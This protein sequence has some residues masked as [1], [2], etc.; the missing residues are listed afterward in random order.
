M[1]EAVE[2]TTLEAAIGWLADTILANLPAGGKLESWIRQAGLGNDVEKLKC[3]VQAV[4]MTVSAVQGRASRNKPLAKSLAL[5]KEL[6]YDADDVVDELDCY[7]L[8]QELQPETLLE[9]DGHGTHQVERSS[10]NADV[11]SSGNSRLR[12]EGWNH[13]EITEFE[14]NGGPAKARC[15]HCQKQV[16]CT[17]KMGTSVLHNHL[18]SKGC[19]NKRRASGSSSSTANAA[20]IPMPIVTGSRKRMRTG[21]ESTHITAVNPNGWNKDAF[22][23]RIQDITS[24]LQGKHG[25]VTRLL[26]ILPSDSVAASSI[27]CQTTILDPCRRTSGLFQGKVYGRAQERGSIKTLIKE[28]KSTT[29]VTVLPIVGIGGVGKTVL[30]QLVYNDTALQSLFDHKIWIWV[31]KDFDEMR[32]TREMLDCV[33]QETCDGLCSFTKLQE[34]LKGHIKSKRVLLILDDVWEVMDDCRWNKLLAPFKSDD[35]ANGN[36]IILTTRK[37]SVAKKRGT[38]GPI[39]LNG[40]KNDDFWLFFKAC[41]FGDENYEAQASLSDIGQIIAQKLKGNPLAAQTVGVLLKDRLTVDHWSSILMTEDWKSLQHTG[42]IMS[43]LKLSYDEMPYLVQQC[44]SYCSIFPYGYE[45]HD[46]ELVRLW[47][48]QGFVK[49]DHSSKSLEVV[50][51][52]YLTDLVNLGLFEEVERKRSSL[53]S[54][55]QTCYAMC[56]LMHD[57]A[58]LVSRTECATLDGLQCS[59]VLPNVHHL[60]IVTD[61]VY[62]RDDQTENIPRNE[63]FEFFL[64]NIVASVRKLR[65]LVL[66]GE[67]D[68]FFFKAFQNVFEKAHNLRLL[69]MSATSTDFNSFLCSLVNPTRLRYLK[70]EDVHTEQK[71]LPHVLSKF[72][73]LQVLDIAFLMSLHT[74]HL[75]DHGERIILPSL[76]MLRFLKRLKLRNMQRVREVL[77]PSLEELVLHGMTDLQRCSCTSMGDMKANLREMEIQRCPALEVFDLFQKGHNYEID[78]KPWLPSLKKLILLD[79]PHL[80]VQIPL[81]PSA[82]FSELSICRVSTIMSMEGSSMG[83]FKITGD[84]LPH[85]ID[86]EFLAFHNLKDIKYL[87]ISSCRNLTSISFKGLSQLMSLKSLEIVCCKK[88]F[89]SDVVPEQTHKDMITANDVVLLSLESLYIEKCGITCKWLSLMLRHSPALEELDLYDCPQLKIEE[90]G[91]VPSKLI[92]ASEASSSGYLDDA[93]WSSV[94][95]SS[96][97]AAHA[98]PIS[99]VDG[100]VHISLNLKKIRTS[101]CPHL[102]FDGGREGFV[103]FT[104]LEEEVEEDGQYG[105][106]CLLPQ[107]LEQLDWSDYPRETLWPCFVGNLTRLKKLEINSETLKYLQ[108]DSCTALEELAVRICECLE[109]LQLHSCTALERLEIW[110]CSSLVTLKGLQSLVNLKHLVIHKSPALNIITTLKSYDSVE[111]IP[112]HSY[113]LF[114]PALE[115]LEIDDLSFLNTSFCKGLTCLRSLRIFYLEDAMRLTDKQERALL[116]LRSLQELFFYECDLIHLP[117]GLRGLPSLKT[118][119]II[120]CISISG[121]PKEGLPT[122]LEELVIDGCRVELSEQC[123]SLATSKLEVK[124]YWRHVD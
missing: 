87:K 119:V 43:S 31:S 24:Q 103:G 98:R 42:G 3:E 75:E 40:L 113:E 30:A 88:L 52:Y 107:S 25:A 108:L 58:I 18:K 50:G 112:S 34:V 19:S 86:D 2:D 26:K 10:E 53:G 13:F 121:L 59:E 83:K 39:N 76:E 73:H 90:E 38:I 35:G 80:Q 120:G 54:Q 84:I 15:K 81:P 104:S 7:R 62:Q 89:S 37:P 82:I 46:Q 63:K 111:G 49:P 115:S 106:R 65:T 48:S 116:L 5:V 68:P 67:Y 11:Q 97:Y 4:E 66:I 60:S 61:S 55:T 109:S 21:Q 33:S 47:I 118:M 69:Q 92:S 14:Q 9:T 57:F 70:L 45:F 91:N 20:T 110:H 17:T 124:I 44:C 56:G 8:Q 6:L 94:R 74:V 64:Q 78:D 99:V 28:H 123:R 117:A 29:G 16:M 102:I 100:V 85:T 93:L 95:A 22:S 23:E 1:M 12:F 72:F 122:S 41:A 51:R 105:G 27:H 96:G 101:G 77:V 71:V 79:C 114:F 32:L 36:T